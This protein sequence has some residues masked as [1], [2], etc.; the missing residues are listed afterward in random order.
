LEKAQEVLKSSQADLE[1]SLT[2]VSQAKPEAWKT[3]KAN[4][5]AALNKANEALTQAQKAANTAVN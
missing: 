5:E 3:A 1:A 2:E 4:A